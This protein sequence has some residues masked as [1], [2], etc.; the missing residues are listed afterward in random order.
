MRTKINQPDT[1]YI[2]HLCLEDEAHRD[3][4]DA[5]FDRN[6]DAINASLTQVYA[7]VAAG[8]FKRLD[9]AEIIAAGKILHRERSVIR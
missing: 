9:L 5:W 1:T 6:R 2:A 3:E 4:T 8:K 7:D